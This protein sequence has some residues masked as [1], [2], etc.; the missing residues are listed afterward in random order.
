ME[1]KIDIVSLKVTAWGNLIISLKVRKG[2]GILE[3]RGEVS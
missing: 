3:S 2:N 1:K